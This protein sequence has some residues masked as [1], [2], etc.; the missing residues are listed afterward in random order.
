MMRTALPARSYA[1]ACVRIFASCSVA[2]LMSLAALAQHYP[3]VAVPGSP[4]DIYTMMEDRQS[5]L[6]FGTIDDVF[7]FDGTHFYSLRPYGFP[8]ETPNTLAEDG[9][10]GVWIGTQGTAANG[11]SQHGG[12][13]HYRAG[14]VE[15]VFAGDTLSVISIGSGT[16][17]AAMGTEAS[18]KPAYGDL[19]RINRGNHAWNATKLLAS[20]ADHFS[21]DR[22]GNILFPCPGG[23]C[24]V[25]AHEAVS[26]TAGVNPPGYQRHAGDPLAE[27][28]IR[29]R[30]GCI[31]SRAEIRASYQC[32][33]DSQPH[34]LP[35]AQSQSDSSAHLEETADGSV[36]MLV[37]LLLGRPGAFHAMDSSEFPAALECAMVGHDGTIW[38]GTTH[39]LYRMPYPFRLETWGKSDGVIGYQRFIR[40]IGDQVFSTANRIITLAPNRQSWQAI[41][42]TDRLRIVTDI[43]GL[44]GGRILATALDGATVYDRKG[45]VLA[46]SA[47]G[48]GNGNRLAK[49]SD[50]TLWMGGTGISTVHIN[51]S[52]ITFVPE[53]VVPATVTDMRY[54][55]TRDIL[56]ACLG[57]TVVYHKDGLWHTLSQ[58][59]GLLDVSCG[60]LAPA[61]DGSLWVGYNNAAYARIEHPLSSH[62]IVH[63]FTDNLDKVVGSNAVNAIAFDARR[64]LWLANRMMNVALPELAARSQWLQLGEQDGVPTVGSSGYSFFPDTDGSVWYGDESGIR[65]FSPPAGFAATMPVPLISITGVSVG[66]GQPQLADT[67]GVLPRDQ[68][69]TAHVGSLQFDRR[70]AMQVRY[71]LSRVGPWHA[72]D[73]M[74]VKLGKPGWGAH[75]LQVQA[76]MGGGE[77][78]EIAQVSL[79]IARPFWLTWPVL[80]LFVISTASLGAGGRRWYKRRAEHALMVFPELSEWRLAA[81]SPELHELNGTL[82]DGRFEVGRILARGGFATVAEGIDRL[83]DN[84]RCAIKIFRQELVDKDWMA[85][86]FKQEVRAL[87]QI[88]HPNVVRI[89]G[90]GV[91]QTGAFYLVMEFIEGAT[92][93]ELLEIGKLS[94]TRVAEYL[95][96][97]GSALDEIHR[98]GICHRD[99]KPENLMIRTS[100]RGSEELVLIDFSIAIVKDPDETL[101]GLSRAAG[102][103]YYM[104]PEQAVGYADASSDIY[105]LAKILIEMLTGQR[106]SV[107]LPDAS[108]DLPDRVR[109]LLRTLPLPFSA[110]SINLIGSALEFDPSRRPKDAGAF[111]GQIAEDLH[112]N[113][114]SR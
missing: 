7:C 45:K 10:G 49:S 42:G 21:V 72:A 94:P 54:D 33:A 106:L 62:P 48:T 14:R 90:S 67:V 38:L 113:L 50:G 109:E 13:Y 30:Y 57:K 41:P 58:K 36:F 70:S 83:E 1:V 100:S 88:H 75:L 16:A 99:L 63:N 26:W 47:A 61:P 89:H 81:L 77:W 32:P 87:E 20:V 17:L 66:A 108:I 52:R 4:H 107:L 53:P 51:G 92:L 105:S 60:Q 71:R 44:P 11:G 101:H 29:D 93:R 2:L 37:P 40:R 73:G 97:A 8:Q 82:L 12:L 69:I 27:K 9:E 34:F 102:T 31:W 35:F 84:R 95:L 22:Q 18:G 114:I 24:E 6:W 96:Q 68:E 91:M 43:E 46:S 85:R 19:Y 59:D 28:V 103:L 79:R 65:H 86:R 15:R 111:A 64:Q 80:L 23:W 3:S 110:A 98:G 78:S 39:G 56:W 104:A 55:A 112:A 25:P 5:R 74:D 76:R